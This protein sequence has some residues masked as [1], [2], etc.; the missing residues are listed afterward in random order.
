MGFPERRAFLEVHRR[1]PG[2]AVLGFLNHNRAVIEELDAQDF[3]FPDLG[4][5]EDLRRGHA[6]S[7]VMY[8][9]GVHRLSHAGPA[10]DFDLGLLSF[11][12]GDVGGRPFGDLNH[13]RAVPQCDLAPPDPL[14][15]LRRK[16][17]KHRLVFPDPFLR[18][19]AGGE[20]QEGP[21]NRKQHVSRIPVDVHGITLP[22]SF[23]FSSK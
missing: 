5:V 17:V 10:P 14:L 12:D 4:N 9:L 1:L 20:Q 19:G 16:A 8:R 11:P 3:D 2:G 15:G 21:Q 18:R 7:V 23:D 13:I 6:P 22:N